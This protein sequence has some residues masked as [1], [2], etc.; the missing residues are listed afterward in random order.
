MV[1]IEGSKRHVGGILAFIISLVTTPIIGM[2][3]VALSR[4]L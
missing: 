4:R 3:V 1:G 2:I